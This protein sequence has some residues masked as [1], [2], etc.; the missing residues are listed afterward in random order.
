MDEHDPSLKSDAM[1]G[2]REHWETVYQ[3]HRSNQVS[4]FQTNPSTSLEMLEAAGLAA[5]SRI[6]DVGGGDSRL[7]DAL[8][9]RNCRHITVLDI[10]ATVLERA[11]A[12]VGAAGDAVRWLQADVTDDSWDAGDVDLWHDRAVLHFLVTPAQRD[13]YIAHLRRSLVIGGHAVIGTFAIDG[14]RRCSGLPTV[15][16]SAEGLAS[17]LGADFH[18]EAERIEEHETPSGSTQRF[19]WTCLRRLPPVDL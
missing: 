12:R 14:P 15:G 3:Q 5:E 13:R 16:Y 7:V 11:A 8:L 4:W 2:P 9:A 18:L 6:I 10:S 19:Q 1:S 17:T